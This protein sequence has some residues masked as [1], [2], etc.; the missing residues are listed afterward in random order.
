MGRSQ[1]GTFSGVR[2]WYRSNGRRTNMEAVQQTVAFLRQ[3]DT[4][5]HAWPARGVLQIWEEGGS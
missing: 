5:A 2:E 1:G 4:G 3:D